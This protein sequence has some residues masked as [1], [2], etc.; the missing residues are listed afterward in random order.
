MHALLIGLIG[1]FAGTL[2]S[3]CVGLCTVKMAARWWERKETA[4]D[5]RHSLF[6]AWQQARHDRKQWKEDHREFFDFDHPEYQRLW[7]IEIGA[8]DLFFLRRDKDSGWVNVSWDKYQ[9]EKKEYEE[10]N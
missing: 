9:T 6:Q 1:F 3:L 4:E 5:A 10:A 8:A 7:M 2:A